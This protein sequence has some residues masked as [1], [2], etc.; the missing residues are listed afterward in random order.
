MNGN[1][2]GS[3]QEKALETKLKRKRSPPDGGFSYWCRMSVDDVLVEVPDIPET[4]TLVDVIRHLNAKWKRD[5]SAPEQT[6]ALIDSYMNTAR[7]TR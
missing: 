5:E 1:P 6:I 3:T 2:Q 7:K 4:A